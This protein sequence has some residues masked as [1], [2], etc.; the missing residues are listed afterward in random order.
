MVNEIKSRHYRKSRAKNALKTVGKKIL[1]MGIV[2]AVGEYLLLNVINL[3]LS[4]TNPLFYYKN[5]PD[6][7]IRMAVSEKP[8]LRVAQ[9]YSSL[10]TNRVDVDKIIQEQFPAQIRG[11]RPDFRTEDFQDKEGARVGYV[12]KF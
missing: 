6:S 4:E 8:I 5:V 1:H 12:V 3:S 9:A 10:K 2:V 11:S 7:I